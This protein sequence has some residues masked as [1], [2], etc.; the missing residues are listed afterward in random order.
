M[1]TM[2]PGE[3]LRDLT[4]TVLAV[5]FMGGLLALSFWI[6]Q[7]FLGPLIWATLL[8]V[9]SWPLMVRLQGWLGGRRTLAA[10]IVVVLMVLAVMVPLTLLISVL[11]QNAP[12]IV[13]WVKSLPDQ[14][15]DHLPAWVKDVPGVGPHVVATWD[16]WMSEGP[17]GL[18]ARVS[19]YLDE[20]LRWATSQLGG[21]GLLFVNGL[22]I[23]LLVVILYLHGETYAAGVQGFARRLAGERGDRATQ[24]AV[25]AIRG[26]ALGVVATALVQAL[27]GGVG[28]AIAGVPV[29]GLLTAVMFVSGIAQVGAA[30]V[31]LCSALWLF[32]RDETGWA[33]GL[34]AWALAVGSLDNVL[35]PLLIRK[36]VDLPMLLIFAGV[37]GGLLAFG[38]IGLF[39]GPVVLAV[40]YTLLNAWMADQPVP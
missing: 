24:L 20:M 16:E 9:A 36:G 6:L 21:A 14:A 11:A 1:R 4:R 22:L 38:I 29:P 8:V 25:G 13:V 12:G 26:V 39:V 31:I 3:P 15:P 17:Q 33:I 2:S 27:A 23:L 18:G 19:P 28:L 5:L 35:R 34:G 32:L 10:T 30:P 37:I 40:G 7:P